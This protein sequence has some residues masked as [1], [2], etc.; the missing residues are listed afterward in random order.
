ML[1]V[2]VLGTLAAQASEVPQVT[3][4]LRGMGAVPPGW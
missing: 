1:I 2:L 3:A 4:A